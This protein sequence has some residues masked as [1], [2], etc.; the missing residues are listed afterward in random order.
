MCKVSCSEKFGIFLGL[1]RIFLRWFVSSDSSWFTVKFNGEASTAVLLHCLLLILCIEK[2]RF[3][4]G[5]LL[6]EDIVFEGDL[7]GDFLL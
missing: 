2:G 3:V 1:F 4:A 5:D 7:F 6:T